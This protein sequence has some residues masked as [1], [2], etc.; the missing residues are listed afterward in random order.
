M[1]DLVLHILLLT[2]DNL[3]LALNC[4]VDKCTSM[5]VKETF[6]KKSMSIPKVVNMKT[7]IATWRKYVK[8]LPR[9]RVNNTWRRKLKNM[10]DP[11]ILN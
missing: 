1:V 3:L 9:K 8:E 7:V 2:T 5:L 6:E 4:R 11:I 10:D